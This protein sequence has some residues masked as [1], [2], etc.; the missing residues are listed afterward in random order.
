MSTIPLDDVPFDVA[1]THY[2][3]PVALRR[4]ISAL[5]D[6]PGLRSI[7][8]ADGESTGDV[9]RLARLDGRLRVL[10]FRE[11]V[12][13]AALAN[14]AIVNGSAPFV[15]VLNADAVVPPEASATLL[16]VLRDEPDIGIAGPR[17]W[18][19]AGHQPSAFRF[20]RPLTVMYRRT[21]LGGTK[22][23]R[24][25]LARFTYS[26]WFTGAPQT[27]AA[28][29]VDWLMGA[30]LMVRRS[31][32]ADTGLLDQAFWMYFEDVDWCRRMWRN[33]WRVRYVPSSLVYHGHGQGSKEGASVAARIFLNKLLR[34]HV[35]SWI[36][37]FR[38]HGLASSRARTAS[39]ARMGVSFVG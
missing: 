32:I 36:R 13:F 22:H 5:I 26:D 16:A 31:A 25:E 23:G 34:S 14:A 1:I 24:R 28:R 12:G 38:K 30:A 18:N 17:L 10:T 21:P 3:D 37:Y 20:Y 11:N 6:H 4:C 2:R 39:T 33:G 7:T 15:M 8:V 29:D 35:R 19:E 9:E 27:W